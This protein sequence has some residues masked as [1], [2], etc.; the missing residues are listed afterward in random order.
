MKKDTVSS[1]AAMV[2]K[3]QGGGVA[4]WL[5]R[6]WKEQD[7]AMS[8]FALAGALVMMVFGG[9]GIDMIHAELKRNKVQNTLDRAVLAAAAVSN[10]QDPTYTVQE[11]FRAM[12]MTDALQGVNVD[13]T[14]STK[15]VAA[16][17]RYTMPSNFMQ[18]LG[19]D[20][21]QASGDA[22]AIHGLTNIEIS[23]VLDISGSMSGTKIQQ[24]KTAAKNFVDVLLVDG[25]T[26]PIT[27]SI[28]PYHATVNLGD[29]LPNYFALDGLHDQSHCAIFDDVSFY[30]TA[31]DPEEPQ[32]QLGHFDP[33]STGT[34]G[35]DTNYTWCSTGNDNAIMPLSNDSVALKAHIDTLDAWGNTA[36]DVGMK[37]GLALL[38][39]ESRPAIAEMVTDGLLPAGAE[40]RPADYTAADTLKF[41]VVMTDGQNTIQYDLKPEFKNP[42]SGGSGIWLS[43]AGDKYSVALTDPATGDTVYYWS[44]FANNANKRYNPTIDFVDHP[45][46]PAYEMSYPELYARFG[47]KAV[48]SHFYATPRDDG[49]LTQAEYDAIRNSY[50]TIVN[51]PEADDRLSI[52]CNAARLKGITVYAIGVEA[53]EAGLAAMQDCASSP[54]HYFDV[55]GDELND[56]FEAIARSFKQ[57]RLTQ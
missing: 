15:T 27:I 1:N 17:G 47:T 38:D 6:F 22:T 53:P 28:V 40:L 42:A 44:R 49:Y 34:S 36:I 35:S 33:I 56:T 19:V 32:T 26:N 31:I 39:P 43:E 46:F 9:I 57:L 37:W 10:G 21:I 52:G 45:Q 11:Y 50:E 30:D 7:G 54:S 13:M 14:D 25:G 12:K 18:L 48:A 29:T 3:G 55:Q 51:G 16:D 5:G 4:S 23:M 2:K 20:T 41:I 8:Y 24:L